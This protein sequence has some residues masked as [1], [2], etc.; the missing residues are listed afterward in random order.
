MKLQEYIPMAVH[1][2]DDFLLTHQS[3][4]VQLLVACCIADILRIYAPEAPYKDPLHVKVS[5]LLLFTLN[6]TLSTDFARNV[7]VYVLFRG[8]TFTVP[9]ETS[10]AICPVVG[11]RINRVTENSL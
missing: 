3:S 4:D 2:T 9:L 10:Q 8:E 7:L 11:I 5:I 6:F 1:I